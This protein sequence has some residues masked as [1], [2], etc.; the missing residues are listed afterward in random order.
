MM[1]PTEN[2]LTR[3]RTRIVIFVRV[4]VCI[5][6]VV[7]TR[8]QAES[9]RWWWSPAIAAALALTPD[10]TLALERVYEESLSSRQVASEDVIGLTADIERRLRA[11]RYDDELLH[12]TERLAERRLEECDLRHHTFELAMQVLTPHQQDQLA[13]LGGETRLGE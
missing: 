2:P 12:A 4:L 8:V 5:A 3:L 7:A 9:V 13:R 6:V 10:Q 11:E 1:K